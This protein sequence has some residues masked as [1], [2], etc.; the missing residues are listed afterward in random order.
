MR[1]LSW[2]R[3]SRRT[4]PGWAGAPAEAANRPQ[5]RRRTRTP[6]VTP[7][8][9]QAILARRAEIAYAGSQAAEVGPEVRGNLMTLPP[10]YAFRSTIFLSRLGR[11]RRAGLMS[12]TLASDGT[13]LS[14]FVTPERDGSVIYRR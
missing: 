2:E 3:G 5:W 4:G 13:T 6:Q 10:V 7:L 1:G 12:L 11:R 14:I 8:R 9:A